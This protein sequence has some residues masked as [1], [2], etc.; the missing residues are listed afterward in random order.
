MVADFFFVP[1][2]IFEVRNIPEVPGK[3]R[4]FGIFNVLR[5]SMLLIRDISGSGIF[6]VERTRKYQKRHQIISE[7]LYR[8]S[9]WS[10]D[11]YF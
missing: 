8:N 4:I 7:C 1:A 5:N 6:L 10:S 11:C 9:I 3:A 2:V